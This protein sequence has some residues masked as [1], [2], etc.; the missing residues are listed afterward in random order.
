MIIHKASL[1]PHLSLSHKHH[2]ALVYV[3]FIANEKMNPICLN[4]NLVTDL[5]VSW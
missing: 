4:K 5:S 2:L 1:S 3:A